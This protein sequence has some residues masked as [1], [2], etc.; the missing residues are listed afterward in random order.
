MLYTPVF[1]H[2]AIERHGEAPGD[3]QFA[4]GDDTVICQLNNLYQKPLPI[5]VNSAV[6]GT[7]RLP[8]CWQSWPW[9]TSRTPCRDCTVNDA[10][11]GDTH[12]SV[13]THRCAS[14]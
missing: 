12:D 10:H 14:P 8:T 7:H 11:G 3:H 2:S 4:I 13:Q 6:T 9:P 1:S 5:E